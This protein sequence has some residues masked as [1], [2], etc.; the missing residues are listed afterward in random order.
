MNTRP[1]CL[2]F[3]HGPRLR[4]HPAI[5]RLLEQPIL[6]GARPNQRLLPHA[7]QLRLV[8]LFLR[9]CQGSH[10]FRFFVDIFIEVV[11]V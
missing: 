2:R 8:V 7:T 11:D 5:Q 10:I 9:I 3:S 1:L 6:L 4:V